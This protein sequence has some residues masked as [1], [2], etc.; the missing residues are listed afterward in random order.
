MHQRICALTLCAMLFALCISAEAQEPKKI[1][2]IGLLSARVKP[3]PAFPDAGEVAFRQG[4]RNVGYT[5]GKN[6]LIIYR[7]SE[8]KPDHLPELASE[9]IQLKV[10]VIVSAAIGEDPRRKAGNQDHSHSHDD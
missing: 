9:L 1:P 7:Y 4:L 6:V 2:M 3:S 5:E 8:G 10:D